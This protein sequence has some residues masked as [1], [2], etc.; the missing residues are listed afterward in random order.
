MIRPI[1]NGSFTSKLQLSGLVTIILIFIATILKLLINKKKHRLTQC[2]SMELRG[3]EPLS[4]SPSIA[5]SSII[6]YLLTFPLSSANRQ[7]QDFS[8]FIFSSISA[9]L[10]KRSAPHS[11]SRNPKA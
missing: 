5:V 2:F 7:A 6:V 8:S 9:K 10:K 3:I 4:E 1:F 11:L